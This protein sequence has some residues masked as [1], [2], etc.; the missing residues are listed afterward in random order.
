MDTVKVMQ[1]IE[2]TLLRE[3]RGTKDSPI[4]IITQYW[5]M[6]GKLLFAIDPC[7]TMVKQENEIDFASEIY[8][9]KLLKNK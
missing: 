3:G 5:T 1:V 7:A 6:D 9:E 8:E 4:R 2:T